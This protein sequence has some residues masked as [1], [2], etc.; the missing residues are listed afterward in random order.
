MFLVNSCCW[1][2]S[3]SLARLALVSCCIW[4]LGWV[5]Y[6]GVR[7]SVLRYGVIWG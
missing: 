3:V 6:M 4:R 1:V 5:M 7:R 2:G